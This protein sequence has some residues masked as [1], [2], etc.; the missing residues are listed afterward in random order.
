M[1]VSPN[2]LSWPARRT[3]MRDPH[4]TGLARDCRAIKRRPAPASKADAGLHRGR[5]HVRGQL[6]Q[7][8]AKVGDAVLAVRLVDKRSGEP[9][10]DAVRRVAWDETG[11]AVVVGPLLG[12]VEYPSHVTAGIDSPVG[13]AHL[14]PVDITPAVRDGVVHG[15]F[16]HAP[17]PMHAEQVT[18]LRAHA[19]LGDPAG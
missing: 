12:V 19:L 3:A 5:G 14:C 1:G 10:T 16:R 6:V 18:F 7:P 13:L 4:S 9:V 8:E 11:L 17:E 15:W 2:G